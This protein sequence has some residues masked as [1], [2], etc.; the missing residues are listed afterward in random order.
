MESLLLGLVVLNIVITAILLLRIET[1]RKSIHG[2]KV[3]YF[4]D[5]SDVNGFIK[6]QK[7][8]QVKAQI[9]IGE[10]PIGQPFVMSEQVTES[11]DEKVIKEIVDNIAKPLAGIGIKVITKGIIG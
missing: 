10:I 8:V 9:M 1:V 7:K 6:K 2:I 5:I 3:M 11:V 4:T